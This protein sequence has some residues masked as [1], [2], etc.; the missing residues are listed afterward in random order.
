VMIRWL[1]YLVLLL[2]TLASAFV[3]KSMGPL[4]VTLAILL[5]GSFEFMG[6]RSLRRE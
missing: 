3:F 1:V 2:A 5:L 6:R 4:S